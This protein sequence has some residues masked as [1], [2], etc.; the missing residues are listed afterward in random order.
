MIDYL[1]YFGKLTT[2]ESVGLNQRNQHDQFL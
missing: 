2:Y 1:S